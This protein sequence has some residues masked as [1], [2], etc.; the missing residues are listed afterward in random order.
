MTYTDYKIQEIIWWING[1]EDVGA[2]GAK[3]II[4]KWDSDWKRKLWFY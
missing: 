4:M 2:Q 3:I 1:S